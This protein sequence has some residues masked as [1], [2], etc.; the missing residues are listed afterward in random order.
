ME[1]IWLNFVSYP[2]TTAVYFERAL[3]KKY[4]VITVGPK[5]PEELIESWNLQNMKLPI[6]PQ[7]I[8]ADWKADILDLYNKTEKIK[9]PDYFIWIE[10]VPTNF[11]ENIKYLP[12]PT[13]CYFI[14]SHL[15]LEE[16]IEWAKNFNHVFIAQREYLNDFKN[17][18]INS[19]HWLP[20]GC[21]TEIHDK[22]SDTKKND[23]GFVGSFYGN[24]R[25]SK[26][27]TM[28]KRKL[29]VHIE[30]SFWKDMSAIFSSSKIVFNNAI[31]ND[32]NMRVFEVMSTGTCLL[33]DFAKNSGQDELFIDGEDLTVYEDNTIINTAE[34]YLENDELREAIA[35]R[36]QE[37]IRAAHKYEDRTEE[38]L[39]VLSGKNAETS[40][41]QQLRNNSLKNISVP[42]EK[43]NKLKRSF[44]IPVIDYS[45]ASEFN[46]KTL[47]DDLEKIGGEIIIIFNSEE[48]ANQMKDD[49]RIDYYAIM[50]HNVGVSRA[51]NIG[52]NISRTPITFII[53]SDVHIEKATVTAIEK[54]IISQPNAAMV[55]P[56]GSY[57][58][59]E[60]AQD[61]EYFD[62]G[63]F[64]KIIEV[65]GVSGFLFAVKTKYFSDGILKFENKFTP[66][67]YEEWDI[68]LQI[69]KAKL[70]SYIVP[71]TAYAHHWSGSINSMDK[72]KFYDKEETA[73][74]IHERNKII[75]HK[76]WQQLAKDN[77]LLLVSNWVDLWL[78]ESKNLIESKN[79]EQAEKVFNSIK[80]FYPYLTAPYINLGILN[81]NKGTNADAKLMF[82]K[83]LELEPENEIAIKYL[84][85][86]E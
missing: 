18:G 23:I 41:A 51:W 16:H 72:I 9:K 63:S 54:T 50:K 61:F 82:K 27:L 66:C 29:S 13:A 78:K 20:L 83:A 44:V 70:K 15:H 80:K 14:D 74:E 34:F 53:N 46:I 85:D 25:R 43:I 49:K 45:P 84:T 32:L 40:T 1:K 22:F 62:K 79:F 58:N 68:G 4:D 8:H 71:T 60:L 69:K 31:R 59:F 67:Y 35:K 10:S 77:P 2:V 48:V 52:L 17:A 30:R 19:V 73:T 33:T 26:L 12:I 37:I 57:F 64:D 42:I 55:G 28:L 39:N 3:R 5:L 76:K 7:D 81:I 6:L 11:P 75:F 24:E 21:D 36:G 38:M 86:L 65:D 47:L 56:Q